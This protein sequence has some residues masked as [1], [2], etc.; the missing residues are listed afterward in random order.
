MLF[1]NDFN[2]NG[3]I[4]S[5]FGDNYDFYSYAENRLDLN[6]FYNDVSAWVQY[7]YSNPPEVGFTFNN[8]RKFRLE[9]GG[10]HF[11]IKAGDLYEFWGRGLVLN[12]I[13]DQGTN[14]DNSIRGLFI[15]YNKGA[16]SASHI[17]GNADIWNFGNDLR[18]P[19]YNNKHNV[20]GNQI[21]F[22]GSFYSLGITQLHSNEEHQK[23]FGTAHVNHR[24]K[25]VY[26]STFFSNGDFFFEYVDKRSF[27][28][29]DFNNDVAHDTLKHGY[30]I[31]SNLNFYIG[32]WG[33]TTEYKRYSF[34]RGHTDFTADDYGNRIAFQMMPTLSREQNMTLSGRTIHQYNYNDERGVQFELTGSLPFDLQFIGQYAHLSRNDTWQSNS[35]TDWKE[36]SIKGFLPGNDMSSLPYWENYV[37]LGGFALDN[38]LYFRVG[39]A[40]NKDIIKTVRYFDGIGENINE[41]WVYTDSVEWNGDWFYTDSTLESVDTS[42]YNVESKLWQEKKSFT[43]PF[44]LSYTT[45]SGYSF[46]VSFEYQEVKKNNVD[47]GNSS[48]YNSSNGTWTLHDPNNPDSSSMSMASQFTDWD[49]ETVNT[50]INRMVTLTFSKASTWSLA[51]THDQSNAFDGPKTTDPF[52]NPLEALVYGD[53][54]YFTGERKKTPTPKFGQQRYVSAELAYNIT[55]SQRLSIMYGSI[56]GGLFCSNGICRQIP[57]FNDGFR[58][59]YSMIF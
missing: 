49:S 14:F 12:Q 22:D 25:G 43:F 37:E 28:K 20:F 46:G 9:Y 48:G 59:N 2:Y 32:N 54:K 27:E 56:Q 44:E 41:N 30:G 42:T 35:L 5:N 47:K 52:Y 55:S 31:Y 38:Q 6:L 50:Q 21:Q 45:K 11:N 57:P 18:I 58:L 24:M 3:S 13:D 36:T 23:L 34:D 53:F 40:T 1:G 33:L 10:E 8:F 16:V 17:N 39:R 26:G 15:G 19:Y 4:S 51:I 29:T 7:E